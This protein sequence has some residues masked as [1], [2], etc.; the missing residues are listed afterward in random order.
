MLFLKELPDVLVMVVT[1]FLGTLMTFTF[2][3]DTF[4]T[5]IFR[6]NEYQPINLINNVKA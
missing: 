4:A 5:F 3:V 1:L 2:F 6:D